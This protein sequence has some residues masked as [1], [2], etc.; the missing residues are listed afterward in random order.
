MLAQSASAQALE[1]S[2][3]ADFNT[4]L[5]SR[6]TSFKAN[7]TGV[8]RDKIGCDVFLSTVI[9]TGC[10]VAVG[11]QCCVHHRPE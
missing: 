5:A 4:K 2:V 3:I 10:N 7:N 9:F 1:K 6:V 8:S 11:F